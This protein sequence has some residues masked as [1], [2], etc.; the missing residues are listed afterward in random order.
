[1]VELRKDAS[2][3]AYSVRAPRSRGVIPPSSYRN[4]GFATLADCLG[5]V[6]RALGGDFSRIYVR[7]DGLCVGER[8]IVEL[9]REPQ[10]VAVELKAGLEAELKAQ[11][12]FEFRAATLSEPGEG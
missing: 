11:A 4:G 8:D 5:D 2:S 12:V 9:R 10:R 1:M 6:A 7:L 3:Y